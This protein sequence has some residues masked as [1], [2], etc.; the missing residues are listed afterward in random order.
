[1]KIVFLN[2]TSALQTKEIVLTDDKIPDSL[3]ETLKNRLGVVFSTQEDDQTNAEL[4]FLTDGLSAELEKK[5]TKLL[6]YIFC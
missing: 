3:K 2:D 6:R 1:M 4:E 5:V